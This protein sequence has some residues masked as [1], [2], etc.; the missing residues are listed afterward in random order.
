MALLVEPDQLF[1]LR[2][3]GQ[4]PRRLGLD[5]VVVGDDMLP[6]FSCPVR[7]FFPEEY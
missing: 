4:E 5:D 3:P 7:D 6:G 1:E 2:R